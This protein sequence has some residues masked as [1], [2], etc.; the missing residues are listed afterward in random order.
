[1]LSPWI[2]RAL[3]AGG[4]GIGTLTGSAH[5]TAAVDEENQEISHQYPDSGDIESP[6]SKRDDSSRRSSTGDSSSR[7]PL[8]EVATPFF[9]FDLTR[10]VDAAE[11]SLSN[12]SLSRVPS[13]QDD[14][15]GAV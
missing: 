14:K 1:M 5:E 15:S 4:F 3:I 7:V 9:H 2:R 6:I 8:Y 11:R 10:A 12:R 13:S